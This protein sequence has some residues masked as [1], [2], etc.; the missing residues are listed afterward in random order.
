MRPGPSTRRPGHAWGGMHELIVLSDLHMGRGINPETRR[1]YALENFFFDEDFARLCDHLCRDAGTRNTGFKLI[2]NGDTF[3]LLRIDPLPGGPDTDSHARR[4]GPPHTPLQAARTISEVMA[5]H[6]GFVRGLA[7]V[8]HAGH[9]VIFLPGN[10]DIEMQWAPVQA[11]VR[12]ALMAQVGRAYGEAACADAGHLLEFLPWFYH[13]PGRIWIEHGC[14]YDPENSFRYLLRGSLGGDDLQAP[15]FFDTEQD[16]P[17]GNFFQRYLYNAFGHIT[18]IVPST[19][20]NLRYVKWLLLHAPSLLVRV[21]F[22]HGPFVY[23]VLRRLREQ[24]DRSAQR[25]LEE[26]HQQALAQLAEAST[27][28]ERLLAI[29]AL[30]EVRAD[31]V[32]AMRA[33]S[34]QALR[35][36]AGT[37]LFAVL[38]AGLWFFGLYFITELAVGMGPKALLFLFMTLLLAL[39]TGGGILWAIVASPEDVS[40]RPLRRA[41]QHIARLLDVA[42]VSFGHSHDEEIWPLPRPDGSPA[43]YCN[44]GTWIAV[45]THDV[46]MPRERVQYTFLRVSGLEASLVQWSPGRGEPVGVVL[47]DEGA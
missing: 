39:A 31:A 28:R 19:R 13:E 9:P 38:V 8:L 12:A 36:L 16:M 33:L 14:Q 5:G 20:A 27:L 15:A 24:A 25:S 47:L 46:L 6:P 11:Q 4:F 40:P 10:H 42:V 23:Q 22:S 34:L 29:D 30:K 21:I 45:F 43:W 3:D 37:L 35:F 41:A 2:F 18:F 7:Q 44:T 26:A 1:Y 32:T 17:L